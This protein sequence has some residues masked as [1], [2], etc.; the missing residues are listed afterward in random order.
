[1][2]GFPKTGGSGVA[3][4]STFAP[5]NTGTDQ[6]PSQQK[7]E[8][9]TNCS[10]PAPPAKPGSEYPSVMSPAHELQDLG[11][12]VGVEGDIGVGGV[13]PGATELGVEGDEEPPLEVLVAGP[14]PDGLEALLRGLLRLPE[15]VEPLVGGRDRHDPPVVAQQSG[16]AQD[17]LAVE[18]ELDV[19]VERKGVQL[20]VDDGALPQ[21]GVEVGL[22]HSVLGEQSDVPGVQEAAGREPGDPAQVHH[23]EV[24]CTVARRRHGELGVEGA[25]PLEGGVLHVDVG[26]LL[27]ERVQ[28]RDHVVAVAAAEEVP[29]ADTGGRARR[30]GVRTASQ[31]CEAEAAA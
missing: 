21:R 19:D 23:A 22:L 24:G 29:V 28:H 31:R 7:G 8:P 4:Y 16:P 13:E 9:L 2:A 11:G 5:E 1:M 12:L 18:A 20:A 14:H 17:V 3:P 10:A 6:L 26:V 15:H 25:P 27:T 30:E